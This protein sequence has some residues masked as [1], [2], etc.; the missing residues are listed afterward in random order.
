MSKTNLIIIDA[1]MEHIHIELRQNDAEKNILISN[2]DK[3]EALFKNH[4]ILELIQDPN[5]KLY[6]TGKLAEI[7]KETVKRGTIIMPGAALWSAADSLLQ[8]SGADSLGIIDLSASGYLLVAVDKNGG[9][10]DDL[11]IANPHCGAGSG[12]NLNRILEKLAI[13]KTEVDN[14]LKDYLG[15]AGKTKRQGVSVRAD[16]CGVFSSSATISDKNQGIPLD[17]ALAVTMKSEALKPLKKMLPGVENIYLTGRV[18]AWQYMRDCATDYLKSIGVKKILYDEEQTMMIRGVKYLTEN[19]GLE[20]FK[21]SSEKKLSQPKKLSAYPSFPDLKEKYLTAGLFMRMA[22]LE[23]KELLPENFQTTPINIGLDVGSTMA[24]ILITKATT[25]EII[26]KSSCDN[27]GD[28]IETIRHIFKELK[29]I[30]INSLNLQQLGLTGSGRY[31]VQKILQKVYPTLAERIF[32]LVENYAHARGSLECA[33]E[34]I[35][36]LKN[37]GQEVNTDFCALVDIG[38]EDTKVSVISLK[39]A[40]LFD[41][42]MN[43]KCSAGTGSLMDTLK[44]LFGIKEIKEACQRAYDAP[45]AYEINATCAVFLM[46]NAKKM[47]ALG[48]AKDE[49]LASANYAIVENMARTLWQQIDFPKNAVVLLHGQTMLSDPLPLAVTHRLEANGKMYCLVPPLPGHRAC[50]GLIN[51]IR[52]LADKNLVKNICV[53]DDFI[54][55]E[56]DKKIIVC[57]GAVCGDREAACSRTQLTSKNLGEKM[58]LVLGGC[59]AINELTAHKLAA[60]NAPDAYKKIWQL[61]DSFMPKSAATN[62]LVIPRSFAIS[63]QAF[64]LAKIFEK[65]GLPVDVDNVQENDVLEA[66][67]LFNIDVCAPLIG[68]AGQ[69][70]RLAGEEHGIIL[71]PQIDFLPSAEGGLGRTCTTNQG[72]VMI[73]Q[74]LAKLKYPKANFISFVLSLKKIDPEDL[75]DQLHRKL[76]DIFK[77]Y[78][79]KIAKPELKQAIAYAIKE[80]QGLK[81]RVALKTAEYIEEA[82]RQKQNITIV[83]GREYILNPGIYDSHIGKLLKDKGVLALPSSAFMSRLDKDFSYIYW[84]NP[85]D[86]LTKI[87]AITNKNFHTF[88]EH[89]RL[90]E[91]IK[92]I[93]TGLTDSLIS[94]IQI[95]T[96]RCGPDTVISPVLAEI[97]KKTPS[98][99]IQS[100]AMIKEL[101]HLENRVNTYI[102]QLNKKLHEEFSQE[103]FSIGL[104]EEFGQSNLNKDT[105]VIYFPTVHD[106]R[107]ITS[108]FRAAGLTAIDNYDDE[109][110]DLEHKI[111]LGRKYAGDSVC[112]PLAGVFAD[113][114]LAAEDFIKRKKADDPK[115]KGKTRILV[116]D[117]KGTGPCRQGQYY[118]MHKLLL[119]KQFGCAGCKNSNQNLTAQIKLLVG[120][121]KDGFN[122]GLP[123]WA[124]IQAFQG[125][126]LQGVLHAILLK[127]GAACQNYDEY[128]EFYE[129]YKKLKNKIYES[130]EKNSQP[131]KT[132][133]TLSEKIGKKSFS[134]GVILK[135]FSYGIYNNNGLRKILKTF[136][137]K[138]I[139]K[140]EDK[141]NQINIH[142]EGEAY[143]RVAQ[144][145]EIFNA[146]IDAIGFNSFKVT[147]SP[148]WCYLEL[149]LEF[150]II[151][152]QDRINLSHE[153]EKINKEKK[154]ISRTNQAIKILRRVLAEPLYKSAK[155]AMPDPMKLVLDYSRQILPSLKPHGELPPY[156]G[157]AILKIKEGTDLF[158]NIAPEGCMVSSMGQ[159]FSHSILKIS[160]RSARIQDLFTLN[161]EINDE[162]L[163]T[164]LLKTLGPERYY[165]K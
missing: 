110:Y 11:L 69:F 149:L 141:P 18:F 4:K 98:L 17:F 8:K 10:K 150:T 42:A 39:K 20:D 84:R 130:L 121:E 34:H 54:N 23:I 97:T 48:Y 59:S 144:V 132:I 107:T 160:G 116:F 26:F 68:A 41:N 123:E 25:N 147:Y 46:E 115:L 29:A 103:H 131:N 113:M 90:R 148:L 120:H 106:N 32:V 118:E 7:V 161:G 162:Q 128:Q 96:F 33:K 126:I 36:N 40:E 157:E 112:A 135:Y 70:M 19:I 159:L 80:N 83:C 55:L 9:L 5:N 145:Q 75:T 53:L 142:L 78:N 1:G 50:L 143:M 154:I 28:T 62:R 146:L 100:D 67:A 104:I 137:E 16:R 134:A 64:F 12:I 14:I 38:G 91:L 65:L 6:L 47:Q 164:A 82:I 105:D 30:G 95:S 114:M 119:S 153:K 155:V 52:Q 156:L 72:G 85:H 139:K 88:L 122:V 31:Q 101:A 35:Q 151:E 21:E 60:N 79:L 165:Q 158:L 44:S 2:N 99:L 102:N 73:A 27:H 163:K 117:N 124:L 61:I 108:I 127:A 43:T 77:Y 94:T 129:N 57:R 87:N 74:H 22:E 51:S 111:K 92:N 140:S 93:E 125:V 37:Q 109:T 71:A 3:I 63:E 66:Q 76:G 58:S 45:K 13:K 56:F 152:S 15:E 86:L 138:W 89:P 133:L 81:E 136:A 49:I 24:K